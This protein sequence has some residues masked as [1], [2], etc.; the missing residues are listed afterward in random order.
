MARKIEGIA[1]QR[2]LACARAPASIRL[3]GAMELFSAPGMQ[4]TLERSAV[5]LN[6]HYS[7]S[8]ITCT[9]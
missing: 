5:P 9:I 4:S 6:A 1:R 2:I 8:E 3:P 7:E